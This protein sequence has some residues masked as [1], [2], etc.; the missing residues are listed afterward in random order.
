[1]SLVVE[2]SDDDNDNDEPEEVTQSAAEIR[3]CLR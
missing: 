2:V 1:M 3:E